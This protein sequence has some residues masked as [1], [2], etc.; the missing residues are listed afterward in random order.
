MTIRELTDQ[1]VAAYNERDWKTIADQLAPDVRF[2]DRRL[3]GWG[4]LTGPDAFVEIVRG[5]IDLAKDL[6]VSPTEVLASGQR[7]SVIRHSYRGHLEEG[8]GEVEIAV[9]AL[10]VHGTDG[11]TTYFEVFDASRPG[12]GLRQLRAARRIDRARAPLRAHLPRRPRARLG[13]RACLLC[14]GLRADRR[15]RARLG[16]GART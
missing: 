1:Y 10:N 6:T 5:T 2:V 12:R 9:L 14:R 15:S 13:L 11:R 16:A 7:A 4:E 3:V 8:G